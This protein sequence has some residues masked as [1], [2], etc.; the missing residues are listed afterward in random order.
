VFDSIFSVE[1]VSSEISVLEDSISQ[2]EMRI[3]SIEAAIGN[4]KVNFTLTNDGNEKLW[5]YDDFDLLITYDADIAGVKTPVTEKLTYA[6]ASLI[7]VIAKDFKI[8]RGA[9][10]M[11]DGLTTD[12]ITSVGGADFDVCTGDCFIKVTD[13]R[14]TGMGDTVG[15]GVQDPEQTTAYI[16]DVTGL[17]SPGTIT[18]TRDVGTNPNRINWEIWEYIG[19]AGGVNEMQVLDIGTC[20]FSGSNV[21]TGSTASTSNNADVVVFITSASGIANSRTNSAQDYIMTTDFDVSDQ[22]VFTRGTGVTTGDSV[23]YAVVEFS[24]SNWVIQRASHVF[25]SSSTQTETGF[26]PVNSINRAFLHVQQRNDDGATFG[27]IGTQGAEVEL[28]GIQNIRL[29][30]PFSTADWGSEMNGVYWIIENTET[31][32]G[33]EMIVQ[34]LNPPVRVSGDVSEGANN[35]EDEWSIPITTVRAMDETAI[36]SASSK[37]AANGENFPLGNIAFLLD[38]DSNVKAFHSDDF[39]NQEYTFSVVQ[40]PRS[41]KTGSPIAKH[42][43]VNSITPDILD[44]GLINNQEQAEIFTTV[45]YPIFPGGIVIIVIS[46]DNGVTSSFSE[47]P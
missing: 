26:N 15:G 3:D 35:E 39:R 22:P 27:T 14:H 34:H 5:N 47:I 18:F 28:T 17:T 9:L 23:S 13:T 43:T 44:P 36:T 7:L 33:K 32:S 42:W 20:T 45:T 29:D 31:T 10:I 4:N 25:T 41:E 19:D 40:F 24:G 21:C 8:Q 38:T 46:S 2:T 12:T 1:D 16:T 30:L 6:D 11:S 37:S